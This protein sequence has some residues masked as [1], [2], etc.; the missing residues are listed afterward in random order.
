MPQ[1]DTATFM[2]QLVW[3]ALTFIVLYVV[4]SR[5]LLPRIGEILEAR[6]DKIAHDLGAAE[7]AKKQAEATLAAYEAGIA[8][9]RVEA[10]GLHAAAQEAAAKASAQRREEA[11]AT[12]AREG[13]AA[14]AAIAAAKGRALGEIRE[15]AAEIAQAALARIVGIEVDRATALKAATDEGVA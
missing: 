3:L 10:L 8:K 13:A 2:P 4:L 14:D 11:E 7:A 5:R 1:L 15:A 12:L 9:A 6:K